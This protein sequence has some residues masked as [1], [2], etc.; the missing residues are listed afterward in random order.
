MAYAHLDNSQ[1]V[2][3]LETEAFAC[4]SSGSLPESSSGEYYGT[5]IVLFFTV[6]F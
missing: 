1:Q 3:S 4:P 2:Y 6:Y 5:V